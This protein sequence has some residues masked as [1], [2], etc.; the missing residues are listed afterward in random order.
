MSAATAA[1]VVNAASEHP[2]IGIPQSP[3]VKFLVQFCIL[4]RLK[5]LS[6]IAAS[7]LLVINVFEF[8]N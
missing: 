4:Q 7:A 2:T 6:F 1:C 8:V 5:V 3:K